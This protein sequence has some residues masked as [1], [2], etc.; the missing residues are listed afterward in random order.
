MAVHVRLSR[1]GTR[2]RPFYHLVAQDHKMRR[3]G[4]F[5]E[6]L[7][8]YAPSH[9]PSHIELQEERIRYW[10]ERG[11]QLS[12]TVSKL[13]KIKNIK[14]ERKKTSERKATAKKKA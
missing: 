13:L 3:D 11:A 4:R 12:P 2:N 14:V 1:H 9:E 8:T 6:N 5:I 7:G 10:Y